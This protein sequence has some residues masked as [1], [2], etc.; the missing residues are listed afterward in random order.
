MRIGLDFGTTTTV[1]SVF[2]G[3]ELRLIPL[4]PSDTTPEV[5]RSVLLIG[6]E[7]E[8]MVGRAAI[9]HYNASNV[10]RAVA[11]EEAYV[12]TIE[13]TF[14]GVGTLIK[15]VHA[16]VDKNIPARLFQS[17]KTALRDPS[18]TSTDVFGTRW[19]VEEIVAAF[20]R[21]V[22]RRI[23]RYLGEPIDAVTIGRP[24]H[25][26]DSAAGDELV[27][28]RMRR[29]SELAELPNI[30]FLEEPVAAAYAFKQQVAEPRSV[31][32]FDFGG[33]TLD[34]TVMLLDPRDRPAVLATGGVSIGGD[35]LDSRIVTGAL[36]PY[37]GAGAVL[38]PRKLPL[39]AFILEHLVDWQSIAELNR[40]STWE[41]VEQAL[42]AADRPREMRA[43][44]ALVRQ[45]YGLP[46]Y[47]A[48]EQAKRRLSSELVA[49]V[50][51][52][53]D[54][55]AFAHELERVEFERLIGPEIRAIAGCVDQTL[56]DAGARPADIDMALRTGGSSRIPRCVRLLADRFGAERLHAM[57]AFTSVGAG[58]GVAAWENAR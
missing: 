30:T 46:L 22:R 5:L 32:V 19:S 15:D 27:L 11:Y 13:M 23:E 31:F 3:Q 2:D 43:L 29:A 20:L 17:L 14:A 52:N 16:I 40:P 21:E 7:G 25:Y 38:G 54:D 55:L 36:L 26:T 33:G 53:Y 41:R 57:D 48:V 50:A 42:Q 45:S 58:L 35:L 18:Y 24:V 49:T 39:P 4:D 47:T 51:L 44:R 12:G 9:D 10:G 34:T 1:A 28:A 8:L 37:F 56:R 6:R